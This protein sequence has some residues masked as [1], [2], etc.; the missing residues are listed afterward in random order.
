MRKTLN[1]IFLILTLFFFILNLSS[2]KQEKKGIKVADLSKLAEKDSVSFRSIQIIN[3]FGELWSQEMKDLTGDELVDLLFVNNNESESELAY[4]KANRTEDIWVKIPVAKILWKDQ[5]GEITNIEIT[6]V[7]GDHDNDVVAFKK[8]E[9]LDE[10]IKTELFWVENLSEDEWKVHEDQVVFNFLLEGEFDFADFDN[11]GKID[12][13]L[14]QSKNKNLSIFKQVKT[15]SWQEVNEIPNLQSKSNVVVGKIDDDDFLDIVY[16]AKIYY[17]PGV[18][19]TKPWKMEKL[20]EQWKNFENDSDH[21]IQMVLV[22]VDYDNKN[23]IYIAHS[24]KSGYPLLAYK[25]ANGSW[26]NRIIK[27]SIANALR[28]EVLDFDRNMSFDILTTSQNKMGQLKTTL[29]LNDGV[30]QSYDEI[31]IKENHQNLIHAAD[32]DMDGDIDFLTYPN[33]ENINFSILKNTK[34]N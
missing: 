30:Y 29:L 3:G 24:E 20:S 17:N 1:Y 15:G 26:M 28:F 14:L 12:F 33:E 8:L 31:V 27:D 6:D 13:S 7:D 4:Y 11:D 18:D 19:M 16:Y 25:N 9:S 22:D 10:Q 5:L 23:E 21:A 34:T 2:C 32:Y